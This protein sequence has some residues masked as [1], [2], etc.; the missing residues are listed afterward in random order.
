[1]DDTV[2]IDF[3]A[4][5]CLEGLPGTIGD[6]LGMDLAAALEDSEHGCFTA[7]TTSA[8]SFY[9]LGTKV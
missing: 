4:D 7:N 6:D 3:S 8:F 5:Y 1:M 9:A 2:R